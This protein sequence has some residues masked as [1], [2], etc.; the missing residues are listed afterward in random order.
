MPNGEVTQARLH[1]IELNTQG[2]LLTRNEKGWIL[3][4]SGYPAPRPGSPLTSL[5][6]FVKEVITSRLT[7][8]GTC[9]RLGIQD[10]SD[11]E[12]GTRLNIANQEDEGAVYR[13]FHRRVPHH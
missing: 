4:L 13:D 12:N 9:L 1:G 2:A 7:I 6:S 5:R 10:A 8:G 11:K 3:P